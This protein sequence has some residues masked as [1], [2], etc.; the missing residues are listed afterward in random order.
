[1]R[2][3]RL[4]QL[5]RVG[6]IAY[7]ALLTRR[8]PTHDRNARGIAKRLEHRGKVFRGVR[9]QRFNVGPAAKGLKNRQGFH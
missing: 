3:R 9:L 8:E 6:Q 2:D 5:E 4:R 1:M 7:A